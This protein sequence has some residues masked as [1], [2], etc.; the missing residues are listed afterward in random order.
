M[1]FIVVKQK[2]SRIFGYDNQSFNEGR[3]ADYKA[4]H[5]PPPPPPC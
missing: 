2:L 1:A 3:E 5:P 4:L